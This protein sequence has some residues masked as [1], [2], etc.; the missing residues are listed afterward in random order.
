MPLHTQ[1]PPPAPSQRHAKLQPPL[2]DY[3]E[4]PSGNHWLLSRALPQPSQRCCR[5]TLHCCCCHARVTEEGDNDKQMIHAKTM[6]CAS[7]WLKQTATTCHHAP[8]YRVKTGHARRHHSMACKRRHTCLLVSSTRTCTSHNTAML[9][10][11]PAPTCQHPQYAALAQGHHGAVHATTLLVSQRRCCTPV[12][13]HC[14]TAT[15]TTPEASL[16][17]SLQHAAKSAT[18]KLHT[19]AR[20]QECDCAHTTAAAPAH[21]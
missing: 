9:T 21:S 1:P 16:Q 4:S 20:A 5:K 12:G 18:P 14:N 13:S 3:L 10:T 8:P 2:A 19:A 6:P 11:T 15:P 7:Q 17:Q